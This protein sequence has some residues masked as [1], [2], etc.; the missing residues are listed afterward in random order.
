MS[1]PARTARLS[2]PRRTRRSRFDASAFSLLSTLPTNVT[3][4]MDVYCCQY[5][6]QRHVVKL[7]ARKTGQPSDDSGGL[8]AS[9]T[10]GNELRHRL[11]GRGHVQGLA[12]TPRPEHEC[13]LAFR[14]LGELFREGGRSAARD[15]LVPFRQ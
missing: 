12:L 9:H 3:I 14:R 15:L 11:G 5:G 10:V 4:P 6:L 7:L 2:A 13:D 8:A 1:T